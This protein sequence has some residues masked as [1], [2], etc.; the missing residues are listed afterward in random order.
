VDK[1]DTSMSVAPQGASV[2]Q[3]AQKKI[4]LSGRPLLM[5]ILNITPDSFFDGGRF[6][7]PEKAL[8]QARQLL[9]EGADIIDVGGESTR[10]GSTPVSAAEELE[11]VLPL[12][13]ALVQERRD[14]EVDFLI[15][16]DTVKTSVA[17]ACI[18]AGADIINDIDGVN[19]PQDMMELV[20][21]SGCGI[22]LNHMR[23]TPQTMQEKP[24]YD[25]VVNEVF[26][27]LEAQVQKLEAL[28]VK[29]EQI[30][31]DPGI[32]FGKRIEDNYQLIREA[33]RFVKSG[34]PILLGM[35]RK[36]YIGNTRGLENSN[37]LIPSV[38]SAVVAAQ[39]GV[40]ILRV[41]DVQETR[42]AMLMVEALGLC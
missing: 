3:L 36:S 22:V 40:Q 14:N 2:W 12:M 28:G 26:S 7:S 42:E 8:E 35:S 1:Q 39:A 20:R 10:P 30:C 18:K 33:G 15:S 9:Q 17:H 34:Y 23:G 21:D 32:G 27:A 5:G 6:F 11:R 19:L 29:A 38:A 31:L 13:E 41:H 37:R 16:V 4:S 25:D 24:Q